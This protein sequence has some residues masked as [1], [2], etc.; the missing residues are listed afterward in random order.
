MT[1]DPAAFVELARIGTATLSGL[2]PATPDS[3]AEHRARR[4]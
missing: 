3:L 2:Y 1:L 4:G